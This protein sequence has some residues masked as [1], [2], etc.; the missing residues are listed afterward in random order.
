VPY[1]PKQDH[2]A[3]W[4]EISLASLPISLHTLADIQTLH[5]RFTVTSHLVQ[6]EKGKCVFF[7]F[8]LLTL[9]QQ[10]PGARYGPGGCLSTQSTLCPCSDN[11]Y[12]NLPLTLLGAPV[13][14]RADPGHGLPGQNLRT[15][16]CQDVLP[17]RNVLA[18]VLFLAVMLNY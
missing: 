14:I 15:E 3:F 1:S 7:C 6:Y 11:G 5:F 12:A 9:I 16:T 18:F 4:Q 8:M 10:G 17:G 13:S 2:P